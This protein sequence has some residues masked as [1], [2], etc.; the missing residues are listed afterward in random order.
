MWKMITRAGRV[1][2]RACAEAFGAAISAAN[3]TATMM[4]MIDL[5]DMWF[6]PVASSNGIS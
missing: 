2:G 6:S 5:S 4:A 3:A 1:S